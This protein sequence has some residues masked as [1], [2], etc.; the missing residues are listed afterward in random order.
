MS[1]SATVILAELDVNDV[2]DDSDDSDEDDEVDLEDDSDD[3]YEELDIEWEE[4]NL[5]KSDIA[6]VDLEP[7]ALLGAGS[8]KQVK[9]VLHKPTQRH[10]A[11][12]CMRRLLLWITDLKAWLKTR[13]APCV[14]CQVVPFFLSICT[15]LTRI[16]SIFIC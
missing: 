14:N 13:R 2:A 8:F 1:E 15:I 11:L 10:Y 12:K 5:L 9:L 3:D 16:R 6:Y 4:G 7:R